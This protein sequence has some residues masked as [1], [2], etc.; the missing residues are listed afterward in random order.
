MTI[1]IEGLDGLNLKFS[2]IQDFNHWARKPMSDTMNDIWDNISKYKRKH[3]T[4]FS[5]TAT[6]R[7]KR[8]YWARVRSG[9][10]SHGAGGYRRSGTL[11]RS[12][13]M[14]MQPSATGLRGEVGNVVSYAK[15]VHSTAHQQP[16]HLMTGFQTDEGAIKDTADKRQMIW[17]NAVRTLLR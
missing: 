4:A 16:F 6:A 13:T 9:E 17:R 15:Y 12:W 10:I 7:Q 3:P 5:D 1:T 2:R 8:A 14:R 11:G